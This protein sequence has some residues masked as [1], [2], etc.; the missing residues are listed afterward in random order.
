MKMNLNM[1]GILS[2]AHLCSTARP[3]AWFAHEELIDDG[4]DLTT[5]EERNVVLF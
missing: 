3:R 5:I 2:N 1:D 4:F